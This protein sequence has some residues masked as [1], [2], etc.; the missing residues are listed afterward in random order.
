[1]KYSN[2]RAFEKHLEGASPNHFSNLY[3]ILVKDSFLCK[4]ITDKLCHTL[5]KIEK[6]NNSGLSQQTFE[7]NQL[8][9]SKISSELNSFTLF[10]DK[11]VFRIN[12]ADTIPKATQKVLE[13]YYQQINPSIFLVLSAPTLNR[14]TN[15]Y[16]KAEKAG[17]V[18]EIEEE[19]GAAKE[20]VAI[21]WVNKSMMNHGKKMSPQ[22]VQV[23][24]KQL[25]SDLCL[26]HHEVEKLVCYVGDRQE[27][28]ALDVKAICTTVSLENIWQLGEAIFNRKTSAALRISKALLKEGTAFIAFLRQLRSQFQTDFQV[29]SILANGGT[30]EEITQLFPYMRGFILD[31]HVKQAQSYGISA[32]RK[33]LLKIDEIEWM[34]KSSSGDDELLNEIL[35]TYLGN[36]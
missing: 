31:L 23:L 18:L 3:L 7:G 34:A 13:D 10:S 12:Q 11:Q 15:F 33:G 26:L 1:M 35:I 19:K 9:D 4:S 16:K 25:G 5:L 29:A 28:S 36:V 27:I 32:F 20:S 30:R 21:E 14:S 17:I 24:V 8:V 2:L 6:T 22:V